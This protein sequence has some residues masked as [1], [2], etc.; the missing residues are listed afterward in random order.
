MKAGKLPGA[1]EKRSVLKYADADG[2]EAARTAGRQLAQGRLVTV[3]DEL[4]I[5]YFCQAG[6]LLDRVLGLLTAEDAG[7]PVLNAV[8]LV[9]ESWPEMRKSL[10]SSFLNIQAG[11]TSVRMR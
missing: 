11:K 6:A 7:A 5:E 10:V 9:P 8:V 2:V 3:C 1:A 4:A